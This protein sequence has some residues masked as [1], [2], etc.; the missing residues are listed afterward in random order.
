MRA[1]IEE[2]CEN[3]NAAESE[4]ANAPTATIRKHYETVAG[5]WRKLAG[6]FEFFETLEQFLTEKWNQGRPFPVM[7]P[8]SGSDCMSGRPVEPYR[9][10]AIDCIKMASRARIAEDKM[11]LEQM[12]ETW[13][14]LAEQRARK[15]PRS[16]SERS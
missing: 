7:L 6:N 12:A 2:A 11:L 16:A 8:A 4:A 1:C 10:F 9:Q 14:R 15:G 5:N 13:L 3:A